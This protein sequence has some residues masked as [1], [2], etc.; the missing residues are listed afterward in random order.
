MKEQRAITTCPSCLSRYRVKTHFS[1]RKV[2][3]KK[4]GTSFVITLEDGCRV[5]ASPPAPN[6]PITPEGERDGRIIE[7][8]DSPAPDAE[9]PP[10]PIGQSEEASAN[11]L[12]VKVSKDRL[13][14]FILPKG[15]LPEGDGAQM[16]LARLEASGIKQGLLAESEICELLA[17]R[18]FPKEPYKVAEGELPLAPNPAWLMCH[19]ET[20]PLKIGALKEGDI[21]DF[22]DRGE[23]PQVKA[24]DLIA[25]VMPAE[26]G[27]PGTDVFG[28]PILPPKP[29]PLKV[30]TGQGV[31]KS[32]DASKFFAKID[33]RPL[34]TSDGKL[35]VLPQLKISGDVG[36]E[37]G[38]VEFDGAVDVAGGIQK[39]FNVSCGSLIAREV[40]GAE[41]V[42]TGDVNVLGGVIGAT[43][44]CTGN[45]KARYIHE[46]RME[47]SGSVVVE[48]EILD[49]RIDTS[50][51]CQVNR[52]KILSSQISA[53]QGIEAFEIGSETARP[54]IL[55]IG[56]D[57]RVE[58]EV[59]RI[60]EGIS[61]LRAKKSELE[62]EVSRLNAKS[63]RMNK[64]LGELAQV[65]DRAIVEQRSLN[66]KMAALGG[67]DGGPEQEETRQQL[68]NLESNIAEL[69]V[70]V[71]RLLDGYEAASLEIEQGQK[72]IQETEEKIQ[73]LTEDMASITVWSKEVKGTPVLTVRGK[74][75]AGT[76]VKGP[77][78]SMVFKEDLSRITIKEMKGSPSDP[79]PQWK[80][81]K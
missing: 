42:A 19:F 39:G 51:K 22:K 3:C 49:S 78:A 48:R 41:V 38:H 15:E 4:C 44:W 80:V 52:G 27:R 17:R 33:G 31:E 58:R 2:P 32:E 37:T 5:P 59:A 54:C 60:G 29:K 81:L 6:V 65:Q 57:E 62:N 74:I 16:V 53:K 66:E 21:I 40:I 8:V 35:S 12:D 61:R 75:F 50:G 46:S 72:A 9:T 63:A 11:W 67:P 70:T 76:S 30:R 71:G 68:N 45:L 7:A 64:Q 13:Q 25:E 24:G 28:L 69:E 1:G 26:E 20:D 47:V 23:I 36:L 77:F 10:P 56:V 43:I 14:A 73:E 34:V 18:P 55:I 79:T